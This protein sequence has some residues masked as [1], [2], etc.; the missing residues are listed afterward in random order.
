[1][2]ARPER[3]ARRQRSRF[4]GFTLLELMVVIAIMAA[5]TALFPLALNRFLPARRVDAAAR[6]LIADIRLA[7]S[8]AAA[9]GKPQSIEP[10][11]HGYRIP[12]VAAREWRASTQVA[13]QSL[14]GAAGMPALRVFADGSSTGGRFTIR[15]GERVRTVSVSELTGRLRIDPGAAIGAPDS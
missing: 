8:R 6:E 1:M 3:R 14:D 9:S 7:Q 15:D 13:L 2:S 4:H 10:T 12:T 11:A 5:L